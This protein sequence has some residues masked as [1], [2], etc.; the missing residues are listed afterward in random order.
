MR[1]DAT[2]STASYVLESNEEIRS[3]VQSSDMFESLRQGLKQVVI[4]DETFFVAEGDTLL[5]EDQ[6]G[7][8]ALNRERVRQARQAAATAAFAG[9][10]TVALAEPLQSALLGLVQNGRIVRWGQGVVLSYRIVRNTFTSQQRYDLVRTNM[11]I[12]TREWEETCGVK[13]EYREDLDSATGVGPAGALFAVRSIDAGGA[14]IA[15]AFFP[16][17]PINRRR[18]LIDP[19]Y[20]SSDLRYDRIGILR[21]ELGHVLGFRHEHI[22]SNAP[23]ACPD[24]PEFDTIALTDYDPQSVMHYFCGDVGSRD[25]RISRLDRVGAQQVYGPPLHMIESIAA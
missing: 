14:F 6:L 13:F 4:D 24:E 22:R 9:L 5:D 1:L 23:A 10:G 11:Q 15:A 17:D 3:E 8:Y 7:I 25:L 12:A 2:R 21:H 20:F 19:S 16:N 18:V